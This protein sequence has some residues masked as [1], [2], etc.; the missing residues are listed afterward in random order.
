MSLNGELTGSIFSPIDR[1][2]IKIDTKQLGV[3]L[4]FS[5]FKFDI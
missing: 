4:E 3:L 1:N 5:S 2:G